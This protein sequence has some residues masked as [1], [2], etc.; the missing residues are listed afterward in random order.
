[1]AFAIRWRRS[2]KWC[3]AE[4]VSTE[5]GR[6]QAWDGAQLDQAVYRNTS[7]QHKLCFLFQGEIIGEL[8]RAISKQDSQGSQTTI[9]LKSVTMS[10]PRSLSPGSFCVPPSFCLQ[11]NANAGSLLPASITPVQRNLKV[12]VET[13]CWPGLSLCPQLIGNDENSFPSPRL[14]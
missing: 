1:M 3:D 5:S 6:R 14:S 10:L 7:T 13:G 11:K 12:D 9:S 2:L 8:R 4:K